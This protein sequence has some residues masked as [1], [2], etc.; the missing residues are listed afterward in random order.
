MLQAKLLL[1]VWITEDESRV[2]TVEVILDDEFTLQNISI[3][4][5]ALQRGTYEALE[6]ATHK[7]L[8]IEVNKS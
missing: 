5:S 6:A 7:L 3:A 1:T 4:G 2:Q 8:E